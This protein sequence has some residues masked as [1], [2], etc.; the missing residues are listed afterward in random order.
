MFKSRG[1]YRRF[2]TNP[3]TANKLLRMV[4]VL[5]PRSQSVV[6]HVTTQLWRTENLQRDLR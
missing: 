6:L 5:L 1:D 4:E 2:L 3:D